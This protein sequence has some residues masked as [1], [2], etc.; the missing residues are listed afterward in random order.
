M[1]AVEVATV[2]PAVGLSLFT[3]FDKG[4]AFRPAPVQEQFA[5]TL[6]D[7]VVAWSGALRPIRE[8][9]IGWDSAND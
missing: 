9:R 6:F 8:P 7:H 4:T 2:R 1:A 5:A 3:D